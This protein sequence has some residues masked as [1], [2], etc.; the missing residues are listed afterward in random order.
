MTC[1]EQNESNILASTFCTL[2]TIVLHTVRV[3]AFTS[4][5]IGSMDVWSSFCKVKWSLTSK[6]RKPAERRINI[7]VLSI[8][9][10]WGHFPFYWRI[11]ILYVVIFCLIVVALVVAVVLVVF[12]FSCSSSF[13]CYRLFCC[14]YPRSRVEV[15]IVVVIVVVVVVLY[16][17]YISCYG[18]SLD[19]LCK[20]SSWMLVIFGNTAAEPLQRCCIRL[21]ICFAP[22]PS[23][24]ISWTELSRSYPFYFLGMLHFGVHSRNGQG[25][26]EI[27]QGCCRWCKIHSTTS[28]NRT[29]FSFGTV[30][31]HGAGL[32][33]VV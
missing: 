26:F 11:G 19:S 4:T 3:L 14:C 20:V 28:Q 6:N 32:F 27:L 23:L 12:G 10:V 8:L 18:C 24:G 25:R 22:L 15:F 16:W 5:D 9:D 7:R 2:C 21:Q 30:S 13:R 29:L 17:C 31:R 33:E 1:T